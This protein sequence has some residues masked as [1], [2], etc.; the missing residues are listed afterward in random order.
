MAIEQNRKIVSS[1][2]ETII[3][4]GRRGIALKDH[5]DSDPISSKPLTYND[6]LL[7]RFSVYSGG[8]ALNDRL[9]RIEAMPSE[10]STSCTNPK[11]QNE[12]MCEKVIL[13]RLKS[14]R[15]KAF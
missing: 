10:R 15:S 7:S 1:I 9:S 12:R 14:Q 11:I 2:Y 4:I 5:R 3:V 13:D 6:G 8:N